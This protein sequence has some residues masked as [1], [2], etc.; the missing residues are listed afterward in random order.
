M[1][2]LNLSGTALRIVA[3]V[4]GAPDGLTHAELTAVAQARFPRLPAAR[5][6]SLISG[7]LAAGA[8]VEADGKLRITATRRKSLVTRSWVTSRPIRAIV[9]DL[10]SVVR[11]T[12]VEPFVDR[13]IFQIGAVRFGAD[14][15]WVRVQARFDRWV[16]LPD[17][18]WEITSDHLRDVHQAEAIPP[19]EALEAL[20]EFAAGADCVVAYNGI[21]ADFPLLNEAFQRENVP[22]LPGECVDAFYLALA[23]WP[24]APT[25]R[26]AGLARHLGMDVAAL[27]WHDAR[28][29]AELL[30]RILA[31]GASHLAGWPSAL[32]DLVASVCPDSTAWRLLREIAGTGPL[33]GNSRPHG[34]ADVV[35]LTEDLMVAPP[36][37]GGEAGRVAMTVPGQLRGVGGALDPVLLAQV[38]HGG[39]ARR[40]QAQE[41]MTAALRQWAQEGV[42]GLVEA[43]TGTGKSLA[44]LAVALD[45]LSGGT[46]RNVIVATYTK[47]LQA[48]LAADVARL[49]EVVPGLLQISDVVKGR[50]NRLSL[51]A[52]MVSLA[53]ATKLD[54]TGR[55]R[56][57]TRNRFLA[58]RG[59]R[60][61]LVFLLL[62]LLAAR[63]PVK[64]WS[65]RSVDPVDV[66]AFFFEYLGPVAV[67]WLDSL[68]QANGGDYD[69]AASQPIARHTD[70]VPEAIEGHRL[71]LANH[72]LL[73]AH[74][75]ELAA[76]GPETLLIID[77]AH[78]LEDAATSALTVSLDYRAVEDL[79]GEA[80]AWVEEAPGCPE[81]D[82]VAATVANLG[83]LL[84]HEQLPKVASQAFDAR[85]VGVGAL[86]G[87]R[88][89]TLA[90]PYGGTAGA[91]RVR[92]LAASL[93]RLAGVA[94]S[95]AGS[96]AAFVAE[97]RAT[98]D[99][100]ATERVQGLLSRVKA[101]QTAAS[102]LST[103]IDAVLGPSPTLLPS[104]GAEGLPPGASNQVVFAEEIEALKSG[105]RTYR[106]RLASS[107]IDLPEDPAWRRFLTVYARTYFV[108]AT[109]R[110]GGSWTFIRDRLGLPQ[111]TRE[112]HLP[113]P[114]NLAEQAELV[115]FADFPSWAEQTE[116]A[117]RTVAHQ[118]AGYAGEM[119]RP[120][121]H[122]GHDGG[123]LV[124]T[125]ARSTAGGITDHL[126]RELRRRGYD[127]PVISA[128]ERGNNRAFAEFTDVEYG[129][130]L[131]VGT[132]GL[133]QGVDVADPDRLRLVWVNKL[134]FAPF[135]APVIEARRAA[136]A[137]RAEWA[138]AD[139]PDMAATMR[140]YLPLAALQLRQAVGRLIRSERHRGVVVISDRK[141]AGSTAL[142]RAYRQMFLGSLEPE[143][144]RPDPE[145]GE[146]GGGN[147]TS[148]AEGW[149]RIWRF[150]ARNHL[151][152][153]DRAAALS[154]DKA[155][156]EH[157]LLP[158]TRGIRAL[159]L[160]AD[161]VTT[162]RERG[163]LA[164][165]V[166]RRSAQVGG[167][168]R[169]SEAPATLKDG[170]VQ[171][172]R[173]VADGRDVL[174]LLPT[175]FGKSFC[176][177][178]P[179]LVLPGVTI[180]VSPL[181]ALMHDQALELNR[182]IG[183]AVRALVAPLR[184][185]SSRA[186]KTEV[187]DQLQG[188]A[189][190]GIK[191]IYLSPERLCQTR[192]REL[193]RQAV[194]T[195]VVTRI[196][197]DEAHTAV[198]WGDD[199]RPAFRR[200]EGLLAELRRDFALPV[201]ALTAT[202]N[203]TVHEGLRERVFGL[204][205]VPV[206]GRTEKLVTVRE[207]PI[208][209]ELAIF[210][211]SIRAA[212][213][214][215]VAGLTEEILDKI[216][217]HSIF[218]CL[219]VKEVVALH[220]HLREYL[221]DAGVKVLR[222]HGRLTEAEKAAVM[223]EF[224]EA[225]RRG[226]EHF[227]PLVVVA[228]SAF[229]L[230]INRPDVRTVFCV[231][232]PTDLAAL[233]QQIG[234]AGRD[235]LGVNAGLALM[236]GNGLRTV[237]FMAGRDLPP[238]LLARM[239]R[240]VLHSQGILDAASVADTLIGEDLAA[241]RLAPGEAGE[242][243]VA[244]EYRDGV[245]RVFA[246]LAALGAVEDLGDFPPVVAVKPTEPGAMAMSEVAEKAVTALLALPTRHGL[247][248]LAHLDVAKLD[249][250]LGKDV[251]GY[252]DVVP[253]PAATWEFLADL[254]DRGRIDVSAAPSRR[255]VTG[256]I[257]HRSDLPK[258]FQATL[259]GR[260]A[261]AAA[262]TDALVDFFEDRSTCAN[263]KFAD[264]FGIGELP[265]GCCT[266]A[267]NRCSACWDFHV[268][269][270]GEKPPAVAEALAT[271]RP[272]PAGA[273]T[274]AVHLARR[275]DQQVAAL[276]WHV[277]RG[278]TAFDLRLALRGE[279]SWFH[280]AERRR[281][282]LPNAVLTSRYFGANPGVDLARI[283][284][285]LT[286]LAADGRAV[287]MG[288]RWR[289]TGNVRRE[290]ARAQRAGG[291]AL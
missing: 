220:A 21:S 267:A 259:S 4:Q 87:S 64:V 71:I 282:R 202:A 237:R 107:P 129:G 147:V 91:A 262:E 186:G 39:Q 15:D 196:V 160:K 216:T 245:T 118:L 131:L 98:L 27:S 175:G 133:W 179:A 32:T 233:Y 141:L 187:A 197:L 75:D 167:L 253:H 182:S 104:G 19:A 72:A 128:L 209:P 288:K 67:A 204:P 54:R 184:E 252:R 285:S 123:A 136:V 45:W 275:L 52:L 239:G 97:R 205:P 40:R 172:I 70:L 254:H 206:Q 8:L 263:R 73:M 265:E 85:S 127:M 58:A 152:E 132:K 291:S 31:E 177:Q 78:Q 146:P 266:T 272:R 46:N 140:Y 33:A 137:A 280:A 221:G 161:E 116:G 77:E 158:Q 283:E 287:Q 95:I 111:D 53:D 38:A 257:A 36:A 126:V 13:R 88:A 222:F 80:V 81:R 6:A 159:A 17:D 57:G 278:L 35:A 121:A 22:P 185:S 50:A 203:R 49:D 169:L 119:I 41:E 124:L 163:E 20:R 201:T 258:G 226:E 215:T 273:H 249:E 143:L 138:E 276:L 261:R 142:R 66:P 3:L 271:P 154:T 130:G 60:E 178:L 238:A 210:R 108:S 243:R 289:D 148:M 212:G 23:L 269:P 251:P 25:H 99:F 156:A 168:L 180:V 162:L 51:R 217:D 120:S 90:S 63:D 264:Y 56:P 174:G 260:A 37:R 194:R 284:E 106:F 100:F 42:A 270:L 150:F 157:T 188:R 62:R 231:S 145:T 219:T 214:L 165:E 2:Q 277:T 103:D 232:P 227:V 89:V 101:V 7:A 105:L 208:R 241:G 218:Y 173:A 109:L 74:L 113:N 65:A 68:S 224:R 244:E 24:G 248:N 92:M 61:L 164:D 28:D 255:F 82:A 183:G 93:L 76:L 115:C 83:N 213:P 10:E 43:P 240:A 191:L 26:L 236:T 12:S 286:R 235:G 170:Q 96:L 290:Q 207:N 155:L 225:P 279:E 16:R 5:I 139:D 122:G 190:H 102:R 9:L 250:H 223:T 230:G 30:A 84:D 200:A 246:A 47:Q 144:L 1:T 11:T 59:F 134:P 198:Q 256:V 18:G 247:L 153:P 274:D 151:M 193:V 181:V 110:V 94:E 14:S 69:A 189:D 166:V 135:A 48:Q 234:R 195:G 114:F 281:V 176:F 149:R 44:V 228:T 268:R 29:D 112:L 55:P 34:H 117:M 199:F 86:I 79:Y 242:E 229:G 125:T 192:M 211:R 171:V